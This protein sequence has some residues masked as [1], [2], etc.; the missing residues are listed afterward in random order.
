MPADP[1]DVQD[2][3]PAAVPGQAYL[4]GRQAENGEL[5]AIRELPE[6]GRRG[7]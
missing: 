6:R 7:M 4:M 3:A 5:S 1:A 2:R